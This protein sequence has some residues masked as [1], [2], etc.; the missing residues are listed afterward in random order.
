MP[1]YLFKYVCVCNSLEGYRVFLYT[2]K[3]GF[4][5]VQYNKMSPA[6]TGQACLLPVIKGSG[7]LHSGFLFHNTTH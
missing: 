6:G 3:G 2:A 5:Y 4:V 7:F 1:D